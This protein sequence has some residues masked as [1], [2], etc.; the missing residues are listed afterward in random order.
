MDLARSILHS[1]LNVKAKIKQITPIN[2][3]FRGPPSMTKGQS[4][5]G[6]RHT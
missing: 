4:N 6:L 3:G 5:V 2:K 1:E